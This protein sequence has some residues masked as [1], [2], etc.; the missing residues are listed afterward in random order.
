MISRPVFTRIC[1]AKRNLDKIPDDSAFVAIG[2][3]M[4]TICL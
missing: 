3:P 2:T 4:E 1:Y